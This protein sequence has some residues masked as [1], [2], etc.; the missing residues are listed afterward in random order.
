MNLLHLH[1]SPG[2]H[3][4]STH[5][6]PTYLSLGM[7]EAFIHFLNY[8]QKEGFRSTLGCCLSF[9][10]LSAILSN[11]KAC[12]LTPPQQNDEQGLAYKTGFTK[13]RLVNRFKTPA[14]AM[15]L[16]NTLCLPARPVVC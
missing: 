13:E 14:Y 9:L 3:S 16:G 11:K 2:I 1:L 8:V 15:G 5:L 10:I 6:N 4:F 7:D 12:A